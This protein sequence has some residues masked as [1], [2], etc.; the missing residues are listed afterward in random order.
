MHP[1]HVLIR[2]LRVCSTWYQDALILI[3]LCRSMKALHVYRAL[4]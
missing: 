1:L 2:N 4:K 3:S